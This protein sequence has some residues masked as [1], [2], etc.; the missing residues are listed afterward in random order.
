MIINIK[1]LELKTSLNLSKIPFYSEMRNQFKEKI[2]LLMD[3]KEGKVNSIALKLKEEQHKIDYFI[4]TIR[5]NSRHA[6]EKVVG[7]IKDLIKT[8]FLKET[9]LD[10]I[11]SWI[12]SCKEDW[13]SSINNY[14]QIS[15]NDYEW[16]SKEE[17]EELYCLLVEW[18]SIKE[19]FSQA[20]CFEFVKWERIWEDEW[21][22]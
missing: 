12:D 6:S 7:K 16:W 4:Q 22:V 3:T 15:C 21:S 9:S 14:P 13:K 1:E 18:K 17:L 11:K 20:Y 2:L 5:L 10:S 19:D 8:Y